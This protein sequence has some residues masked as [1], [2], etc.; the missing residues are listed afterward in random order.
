MEL[1]KNLGQHFLADQSVL[2]SIVAAVEGLSPLN[3]LIE[4]GPGMGALTAHL[5]SIK[6]QDFYLIEKDDRFVLEL[7]KKFPELKDRIF[8]QDV[9][10]FEIDKI[11]GREVSV[12]GNYP[13]NISN[14]IMFWII[15]N[16]DYVVNSVGMFQKEVAK[17]IASKSGTKDYGVLSVLTQ[18]IYEVEYLFDIPAEAFDP[19]P[20][21][22][23]GIIKMMRRDKPLADYTKL[24]KLVK[25]A[26][27]QRRK[28]LSNSL[29]GIQ[30]LE[31]DRFE[32]LKNLRPEQLSLEDFCQLSKD[33][34]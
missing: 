4:V 15:E 16:S 24:K 6:T 25:A 14:L 26:F 2:E 29:K 18:S 13:Y 8:H 34:A 1:K 27:N 17:R 20:K 28:M 30:F 3:I 5:L 11:L 19:P 21:V 32:S 33:L 31:T 7:P 22:V 23:S 9:L 12:V 10:T